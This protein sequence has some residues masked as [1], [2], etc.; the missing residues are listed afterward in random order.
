MTSP[1]QGSSVSSSFLLF[2]GMT[3]GR[4][5]NFNDLN[6]PVFGI[7]DFCFSVPFF[8]P[9]A[10]AISFPFSWLFFFFQFL[11]LHFSYFLRWW[12]RLFLGI[13]HSLLFQAVSAASPSSLPLVMD[14][15]L[16]FYFYF[17]HIFHINLTIVEWHSLQLWD[18]EF[19]V[20]FVLSNV[21]F[22]ILW[23]SLSNSSIS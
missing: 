20:Y 3:R 17:I 2:Y 14:L 6:K 1:W 4:L 10:D 9:W 22:E 16:L 23:D 15:I 7:L 19:R 21:S 8:F 11:H 13:C 12:S 18:G 5:I